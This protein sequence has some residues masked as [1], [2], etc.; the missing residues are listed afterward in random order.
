MRFRLDAQ[1]ITAKKDW[2]KAQ[3][4]AKEHGG[5]LATPQEHTAECPERSDPTLNG[6]S[7]DL[8]GDA[9]ASSKITETPRDSAAYQPEMD[10]MRCI[11]YSHGGLDNFTLRLLS[12]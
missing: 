7:P 4:R 10:A 9:G 8:A 11:L 3:K 12:V 1:W 2:Q 6:L 5:P